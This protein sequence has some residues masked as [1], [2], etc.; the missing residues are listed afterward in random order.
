MENAIITTATATTATGDKIPQLTLAKEELWID[1]QILWE[2]I[3]DEK[4]IRATMDCPRIEERAA[5]HIAR[6]RKEGKPCGATIRD[7]LRDYYIRYDKKL[8][9]KKCELGRAKHGFGRAFCRDS[10][11]FAEMERYSRNTIANKYYLDFDM[12][13]AQPNIINQL[14]IANG[15]EDHEALKFYCDNREKVLEKWV[16][17]FKLSR[18]QAKELATQV[19]FGADKVPYGCYDDLLVEMFHER[20]AWCEIL[21]AANP[22]LYESARQ[23]NMRKDKRGEKS[24]MNTMVAWIGQ[25]Y[26]TRLTSACLEFCFKN[27]LMNN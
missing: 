14:L 1:N 19:I 25:E 26:E 11:S 24:H 27:G 5:A 6:M 4:L 23:S 12:K 9:A 22:D 2:Y 10:K 20:D 7:T 21:K 15:Y 16:K 8:K 17:K 3:P 18:D 13:N